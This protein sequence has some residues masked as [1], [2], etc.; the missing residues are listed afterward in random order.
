[1]GTEGHV[2]MSA[3]RQAYL[4]VAEST[5][6]LLRTPALADRWDDPSALAQFPVSGLAG[7]LAWQILCVPVLLADAPPAEPPVTVLDHYAKSAWVD[8]SI[9][10]E[11]NVGIRRRGDELAGDGP[12][13]LADR[14]DATVAQLRTALAAEPAD[15]VVRARWTTWSLTLDDFLLTRM[16]ELAVHGDDLAVSVDVPTPPLPAEVHQPVLGLLCALSARRHGATAVLRA[17]SRAE[18]APATI[19]AF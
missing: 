17:L 15:R 3:I 7:H 9:D 14:V 19:A 13:A 16:M 1:M 6:A 2:A 4:R 8:A 10:D 5:A 12:A 11:I 18:R